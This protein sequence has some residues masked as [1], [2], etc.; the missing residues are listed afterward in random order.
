M[1]HRRKTSILSPVSTGPVLLALAFG[2]LGACAEP[3]ATGLD[4]DSP[5]SLSAK[6]N[7]NGG[8]K[9]GGEESIVVSAVDPDTIA[10]DTI[11]DVTVSGAN[12]ER[13]SVV[14]WELKGGSTEGAILTN[15]T[16]Y[17]NSK[18]LI[19]NITISADALEA[20]YDAVVTPPKG[21]RGVGIEL[22][23]IAEPGPLNI[24]FDAGDGI[25]SDNADYRDG[26]DGVTAEVLLIGNLSLVLTNSNRCWYLNFGFGSYSWAGECLVGKGRI[27][28][29]G[30]SVEGGFKGLGV[31]DEMLTASQVTW[32]R[33]GKNWFLRFG[34]TCEGNGAGDL[35]DED[36]V[37]ITRTGLG[38]WTYATATTT[39]ANPTNA[40]LC[41]MKI[42]GKPSIVTEGE[43]DVS[44]GMTLRAQLP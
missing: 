36:R 32:T 4:G 18:K 8:G 7:G 12:F 2:M 21:R 16:R 1:S 25:K 9:G 13:E 3:S 23:T 10:R 37:T 42:K 38:T 5:S 41:S 24:S 30:P 29:L 35:V 44:L 17:V 43:F 20:S 31:D 39:A 28:T 15:S 40:F 27:T 14:S 19:A 11:L 6:N 22:V 33:D 26:I 34:R